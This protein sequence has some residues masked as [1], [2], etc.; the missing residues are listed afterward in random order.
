LQE[1]DIVFLL[2]RIFWPDQIY[3]GP[4]RT[5]DQEEIADVVV[6]TDRHVLLIQAKSSPNTEQVLHNTIIRKKATATKLPPAKAGGLAHPVLT[7]KV[8]KLALYKR[9]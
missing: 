6:I 8:I 2:Q 4:R 5:T 7:T 9:A 3:L 1:H